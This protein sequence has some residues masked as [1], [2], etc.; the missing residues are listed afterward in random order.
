MVHFFQN[1]TS[2]DLDKQY[3][4]IVEGMTLA[5][6]AEYRYEQYGIYKGEEASYANYA[7]RPVTYSGGLST[8]PATGAQGFPGF[9]PSDAHKANRSNI[10]AYGDAAIDITRSWLVDGAVRLENYSDF[11]FVSTYKLATRVKLPGNINFRCSVSTGYRAPS[12]Q[13]MNFSNTESNVVAGVPRLVKIAPSYNPITK[14]AGIPDI[15][16]ERSVSAGRRPFHVFR[17]G[18]VGRLWLFG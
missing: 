4:D 5:F 15:K 10:A 12:L 3:K 7:V 18:Q 8:Y 14:A 13:Q 17:E 16:Q 6:G 11:G 9:Q 2:L 1:T